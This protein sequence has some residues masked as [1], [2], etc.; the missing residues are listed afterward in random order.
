MFQTLQRK[1][2]AINKELKE[3]SAAKK[4]LTK[5]RSSASTQSRMRLHVA[6]RCW[7]LTS[8]VCCDIYI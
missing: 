6:P 1:Q 5:K 8:V 3:I 7:L 2:A 4:N